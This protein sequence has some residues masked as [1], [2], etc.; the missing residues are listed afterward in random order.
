MLLP[1]TLTLVLLPVTLSL[2]LAVETALGVSSPKLRALPTLPVS[3]ELLL[4][5]EG[6]SETGEVGISMGADTDWV[7]S[8][9]DDTVESNTFVGA[10]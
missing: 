3:E 10:E 8:F 1:I 2:V 5:C 4:I 7:V 9:V 6:G